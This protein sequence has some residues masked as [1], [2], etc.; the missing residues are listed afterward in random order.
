MAKPSQYGQPRVSSTMRGGIYNPKTEDRYLTKLEALSG[1]DAAA[2]FRRLTYATPQVN[3]LFGSSAFTTDAVGT[4]AAKTPLALNSEIFS[5]VSGLTMRER[6]GMTG[7][8]C[9]RFA[10]SPLLHR[11]H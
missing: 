10:S 9:T 4:T 5:G 11:F 2:I 1:G 3:Y 7:M 6:S 8:F